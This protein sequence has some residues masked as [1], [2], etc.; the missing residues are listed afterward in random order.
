MTHEELIKT[1]DALFGQMDYQDG[2]WT[3]FNNALGQRSRRKFWR[4]DTR[5]GTLK[6]LS[7]LGPRQ[8]LKIHNAL[9][10]QHLQS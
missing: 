7:F 8:L 2:I 10:T 9:V 5:Y 4:N 6:A 1:T 3:T